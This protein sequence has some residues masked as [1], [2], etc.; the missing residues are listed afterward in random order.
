MAPTVFGCFDSRALPPLGS[1]V[2]LGKKGEASI[3]RCVSR[4]DR[5]RSETE[6]A[7]LPRARRQWLSERGPAWASPAHRP[8]ARRHSLASL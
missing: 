7:T 1:D 6:P 2:V 3:S 5:G 4:G 8:G